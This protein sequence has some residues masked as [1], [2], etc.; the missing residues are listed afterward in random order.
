MSYRIINLTFTF[1][2]EENKP[3]QLSGILAEKITENLIP[4]SNGEQSASYLREVSIPIKISIEA[5]KSYSRLLDYL[6]YY[7][8]NSQ[9]V[10]KLLK[11]YEKYIDKLSSYANDT[12]GQLFVST[13]S[14][15]LDWWEE[16]L[17]LPKLSG[18]TETERRQ[19]I[20][21]KLAGFGIANRKKVK[22]LIQSLTFS[23]VTILEDYS[24]YRIII[25]GLNDIERIR[26]YRDIIRRTI[27]SHLLLIFLI[28]VWDFLNSLNLTWDM[29]DSMYISWNELEGL[30]E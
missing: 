27:P 21:G 12:Q 29:L 3:L 8:K 14:W 2:K 17:E 6:P 28:M 23:N 5:L 26:A 16:I 24:S 7:Y 22:E 10:N 15:A 4:Y 20:L 1:S 30:Y 18:L 25:Y 11:I 13:S 9:I 19:R